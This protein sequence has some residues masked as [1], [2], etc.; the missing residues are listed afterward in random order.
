MIIKSVKN[1]FE[2]K[3]KSQW[4]IIICCIIYVVTEIYLNECFNVDLLTAS[5]ESLLYFWLLR[6][7]RDLSLAI[8]LSSL[9]I[10]GVRSLRRN[11]FTIKRLILPLLAFLLCFLITYVTIYG[12][13][14]L[15][16]IQNALFDPP[17]KKEKL[18]IW[19]DNKE[20]TLSQ[21]SKISLIYAR[22]IWKETGKTIVYITNDGKE[23]L[24]EPSIEEIEGKK[25]MTKTIVLTAW[26]LKGMKR[27][28]ILW[29]I[30]AFASVAIGFFTPI[31]RTNQTVESNISI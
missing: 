19:L 2:L 31:K 21:R 3:G 17:D 27:A 9:I 18:E 1:K 15:S 16:Q 26:E 12:Q 6:L 5:K 24:Y 22:Q 8:V 23:R 14:R 25:M 30:I 29:P 28:F 7:I 10:L 11:G 20:L 4:M 13:M